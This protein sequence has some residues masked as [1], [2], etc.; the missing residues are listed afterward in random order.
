[1]FTYATAIVTRVGTPS[2]TPV[3]AHQVAFQV[4]LFLALAVDS[5]AIAAQALVGRHR[6]A[7]DPSATREVADRLAF[8]G[9]VVGL[10]L[11]AVVAAVRPWLPGWFTAEAEVAAAIGGIYW[12]LVAGLPLSALVFVWD[13]VFLGA[14]DFGYLAGATFGAALVGV[15]LLSLV[16]PFGWGLAGVW[17]AIGALMVARILTLVWRRSSRSGPLR[18]PA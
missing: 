8:L 18:L 5:L 14:G 16:L 3:A 11:A 1:M 6:G 13:G 12:F 7:G 10:V 9:L 4:W 17:W 2:S 15:G